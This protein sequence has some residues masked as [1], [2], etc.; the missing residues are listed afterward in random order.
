MQGGYF[1]K[2]LDVDLSR[3]RIL[4]YKTDDNL[5]LTYLGGKG[6]AARILY[7]A[8]PDGANAFSPKNA[9]IFTAGPLTG[10]NA[11]CS[12]RFNITTKSPL[13]G[14][15]ASSN[16]GGN[17]AIRLRS[18][19]YDGLVIRGRAKHPV[20]I[21]I[22]EDLV[23]IKS[24][25]ALW[26]L[27]TQETQ[28]RITGGKKGCAV[29]GPAGENLVLYASVVSQERTA[30]RGGAGAVLGAK[31]VKA[32]VAGGDKK[33]PIAKPQ[34]FR[35]SVRRW[36]GWLRRHPMTGS[37]LSGFGTSS[38]LNLASAKSVLPTRNF[39]KGNFEHADDIGGE[40]L[41]GYLKGTTGCVTCPIRC[42]RVVEVRGE[43]MKGPEYETLALMGAN[44]GIRDIKKIFEWNRICDLM[45]MDT[46]SAGGTIAFAMELNEKG[47]MRTNLGFGSPGGIPE[48]L[49]DIA[50]RNGA[51]AELADGVRRLS[52]KYGGKDF[53]A[54][55]KGLEAAGYEPR[56][57]FGH[58]LGY[59]T[60][61]R[62][63]CHI[64][65]GYLVQMEA[66]GNITV[67]ARTT[68]SKPELAVLM[69]NFLDAIG[70][71]VT[72]VFTSYALYPAD[73]VSPYGAF[74]R[75]LSSAV[76]SS[77]GVIGFML[78]RIREAPVRIP[79]PKIS[80]SIGDY[81][82][83]FSF[84]SANL[85]PYDRML[86]AVLGVNFSTSD[87]LRAGERAFN[88]ERLFNVR[89]GIS[90]KDDVLPGR[91]AEIP[92]D[93]MLRRYYEVRGWDENGV[94]KRETLEKLGI[95]I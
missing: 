71:T 60:A 11:P 58:G 70:C 73:G 9:V 16:C 42:G 57:A 12:S 30:G 82:V 21:D 56:N 80:V 95:V 77:G 65:G 75:L 76:L 7:D 63:A 38:I 13:T 31:K 55:V 84:P 92:L 87:F 45:G 20:Y 94:P 29:I 69:Q 49:H 22:T 27:D 67:D 23:K 2:I 32:I 86:S 1:G 46:M 40:K 85:T 5:F 61:N 44:L 14:C 68:N 25:E 78:R 47:L 83:L 66:L 43:K 64:G 17:F 35:D 51:G 24:A 33:V 79:F 90:K 19:G 8:V 50:T 39:Q 48:M 28:K 81:P 62:G 34:E 41:A 89:E 18:A 6:L 3:N 91:W 37:V 54:H 72:C 26:G 53:A 52:E 36:T 88:M 93:K 74:G 10:T 4:L 15:I 59:A